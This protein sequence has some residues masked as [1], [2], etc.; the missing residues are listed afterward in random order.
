MR[1]LF[2]YMGGP[3]HLHPLVPLARG[4][5]ARG[6][7]V[8]FV[9]STSTLTGIR[10][11][12]F[13]PLPVPRY[14]PDA[15]DIA[16]FRAERESLRTMME[17]EEF[18]IRRGFAGCYA[19]HKAAHLLSLFDEWH[20]DVVVRDE[21]DFGACIAAEK[22]DI[23]H[24]AV[25]ILAAGGLARADLIAASL[26][27][28]REEYH[29]PPDPELRM[30]WRY[31]VLA[32]FPRRFRDP[33]YPLPPTGHFVRYLPFAQSGDEDLPAWVGELSPRPTVYFSLGTEFNVSDQHLFDPVITGLRNE[34]IN[35]VVTVGRDLDPAVLGPQP[36]NVR[37]ERYIPLPA[38]A[39]HCDA[40]VSHGGT[41]T[42]MTALNEGVPMILLPI[43]ADQPHNA[44]RCAALGVARIL[45]TGQ[46]TP[47]A[48]RD[49]TV[50][51]LREPAYRT[52]AQRLRKEMHALPDLDAQ[53]ALVERVAATREPARSQPQHI[54]SPR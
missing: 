49:A 32:P 12:G 30:P 8:A 33:R 50:A 16:R 29:L 14:P 42:I 44:A 27:E 9:G 26:A 7:E 43:G 48:V 1:V 38:L 35:L 20:P 15:P 39:P 18:T 21:V 28:I 6:H 47:E 37:V 31:L 46:F 5:R 11:A 52:E 41:G 4:L 13:E 10:A 2:T 19:R 24:V 45:D 54:E 53:T 3:G 22:W 25:L 34:P 51:V 17:Q 23:P 36:E 40:I